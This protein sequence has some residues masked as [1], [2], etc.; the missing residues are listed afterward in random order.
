MNGQHFIDG[1]IKCIFME[2]I[3]TCTE[4]CAKGFNRQW[5]SIVL[6]L[7]LKWWEIII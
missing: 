6:G 3:D 5:A 4:I 7:M 2:E 1:I